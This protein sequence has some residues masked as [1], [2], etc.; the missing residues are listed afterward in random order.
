MNALALYNLTSIP[1]QQPVIRERPVKKQRIQTKA[2][3][4]V[5]YICVNCREPVYLSAED[6]IQ[7]THCE[8][9]IVAKLSTSVTKTYQAV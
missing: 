4:S 3:E 5:K 8:N 6:V 9:R 7:C 2:I 1:E